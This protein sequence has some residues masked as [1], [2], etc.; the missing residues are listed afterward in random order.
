MQGI[1]N[2]AITGNGLVLEEVEKFIYLGATVCNQGGGE[3]D[4]KARL[5]KGEERFVKLNRVWNSSSVSRKTK[6]RLC[7]TS[8]KPVLMYG[9]EKRKMNKI[10]AKKIDMF[11]NRFPRRIMKIK[12]EDKIRNRELMERGNVERLIQR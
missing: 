9:C 12:W 6:I 11:Q 10:D 3:E 5:G 7:K 2:E 8:V 1:I 4:I